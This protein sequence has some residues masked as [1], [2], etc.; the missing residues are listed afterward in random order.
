MDIGSATTE[1]E[2]RLSVMMIAFEILGAA[3]AVIT[4]FTAGIAVGR[5]LERKNDRQ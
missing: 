2:R 4:I 3:A 5:F 1:V